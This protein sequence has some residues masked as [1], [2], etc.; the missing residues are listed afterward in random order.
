VPFVNAPSEFV[1]KKIFLGI[2]GEE[3][4]GKTHIAMSAPK[5][6]Y[7]IDMN[8]GLNGVIQKE[9][10][11]AG[12]GSIKVA[13]HP[14]P[15]FSENRDTLKTAAA[16]V[17]NEMLKDYTDALTTAK[18]VLVDGGTELYK[19]ARWA[20]FGGDKNEG[21]RKGAL[22]YDMINARMRGFYRLYYA[23]KA[24]LIVTHQ[25]EDEWI[26]Y[27]KPDGTVASRKSGKLV[28]N[29]WNDFPFMAEVGIRVGKPD[30]KFGA[31]IQFC[32]FAPEIEGNQLFDMVDPDTGQT[33]VAMLNFPYVAS[34]A[35]GTPEEVW[36]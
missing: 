14:L 21:S 24:S 32:R 18:S 11:R 30:G 20:A 13:H 22:D 31:T 35:T 28:N 6:L 26:Q 34:M 4:C 8:E 7:V 25:V 23:N 2:S 33:L 29:G 16:R 17:W 27:K 9:V 36:R 3:K 12:V 15:P 19:L 1:A 10:R 5:P